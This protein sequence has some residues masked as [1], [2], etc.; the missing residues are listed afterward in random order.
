[1]FFFILIPLVALGLL[2]WI[3]FVI[4][5][6]RTKVWTLRRPGLPLRER[7]R[8]SSQSEETQMSIGLGIPLAALSLLVGIPIIISMVAD[9]TATIT[10]ATFGIGGL[11]LAVVLGV[12]VAKGEFKAADIGVAL[13]IG[14]MVLIPIVAGIYAH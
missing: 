10:V 8:E 6:R 3:A 1:M 5:P 9:T 11:L 14:T 4:T 2:A 7:M 13:F 12:K